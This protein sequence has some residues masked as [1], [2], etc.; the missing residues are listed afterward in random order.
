MFQPQDH[1]LDTTRKP[2]L[3]REWVAYYR[4][5]PYVLCRW[6]VQLLWTRLTSKLRVDL[7]RVG[8]PGPFT[9]VASQRAPD[10]P[11]VTKGVDQPALTQ[12]VALIRDR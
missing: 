11:V 4:G 8:K 12:P 3:L 2:H 7:A 9:C 6:L 1:R 10:Q 5:P